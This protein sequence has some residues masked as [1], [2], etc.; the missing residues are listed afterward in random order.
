[1]HSVDLLDEYPPVALFRSCNG[2]NV[3]LLKKKVS[4]RLG[5]S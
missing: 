5:N 3:V 2:C 1:M 4:L